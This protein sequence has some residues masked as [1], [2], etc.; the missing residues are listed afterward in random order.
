[1]TATD[2]RSALLALADR[3]LK[4][5]DIATDLRLG[6]ISVPD[7]IELQDLANGYA[8]LPPSPTL[9]RPDGRTVKFFCL[10]EEV[11]R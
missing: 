7:V 1:M 6:V 4:Y 11:E 3:A 5:N 8:D 9:I 10:G 2:N